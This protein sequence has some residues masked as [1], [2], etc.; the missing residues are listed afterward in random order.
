MEQSPSWKASRSSASQ[1]IFY[2]L[3]N[4]EF[5]YCIYKSPPPALIHSRIKTF[6]APVRL[7]DPSPPKSCKWSPSIVSPPKPC[8]H[9]SYPIRA[10]FP[11]YLVLFFRS[12]K[13]YIVRIKPLIMQSSP[14]PYY[15]VPLGPKYLTP[16]P[17]I[18]H[19]H[20]M[21]LPEFRDQV[22]HPFKLIG[23]NIVLYILLFVFLC[24]ELE[25]STTNYSKHSL[26]SI[27]S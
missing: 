20:P 7:E 5:R 25:D 21:I 11:G 19:F 4:S 17:A 2:I 6:H 24:S 14:L 27:W 12:P 9:L 13:W 8:M 10:T 3:W 16:R 22:L 18:E 26:T 15:F 1:E 23:K